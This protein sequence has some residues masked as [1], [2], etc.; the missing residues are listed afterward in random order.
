M[1]WQFHGTDII[2]IS[3]T[4]DPHPRGFKTGPAW[5]ISSA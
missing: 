2:V 5:M 4:G 3:H 1:V